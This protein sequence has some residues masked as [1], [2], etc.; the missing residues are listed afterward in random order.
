[1]PE[2]PTVRV[3][4]LPNNL[5]E[6]LLLVAGIDEIEPGDSPMVVIALNGQYVPMLGGAAGNRPISLV[7]T[8]PA[9][10]LLADLLRK[11]VKEYLRPPAEGEA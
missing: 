4:E 10:T 8:P 5:G 1:M 11:G 9:A 2:V 7:L 6:Q 3:D